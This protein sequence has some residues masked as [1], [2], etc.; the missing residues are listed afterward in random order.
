HDSCGVGFVAHIKG[1]TSHEIV[2]NALTMLEHM[3]HRGA[4]GCEQN[5]G[6]GAGILFLPTDN[7]QRSVC[8]AALLKI[9]EE[10]G[11]CFLGWRDVPVDNS[12]IGLSARRIE[13]VM[14]IVFIGA[15][16]GTKDAEALE[17]QLYI[18]RKRATYAC[19]GMDMSQANYFYIC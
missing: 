16:E 8:E 9:I 2:K 18:I 12:T 14:R 3:D 15:G 11:Q 1:K 19:R 4:C 13:P 17:R 10:Q 5:T 6:D 7:E